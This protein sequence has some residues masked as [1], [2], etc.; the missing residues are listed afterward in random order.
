MS[1]LWTE[2]IICAFERKDMGTDASEI[3]WIAIG[4]LRINILVETMEVDEGTPVHS[5]EEK[6]SLWWCLLLESHA[7][8][9]SW[10]RSQRIRPPF[11][12]YGSLTLS[13][14]MKY[15]KYEV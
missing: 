3:K 5:D 13:N 7:Y 8:V 12:R 9:Q 11:G 6:E 10:M 15:L 2:G 1:T 14:G 4:W